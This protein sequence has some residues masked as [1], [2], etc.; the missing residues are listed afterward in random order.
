LHVDG[1]NTLE[2]DVRSGTAVPWHGLMGLAL[3]LAGPAPGVAA[4]SVPLQ[5]VDGQPIVELQ[6]GDVKADFVLES[7]G[8]IGLTVPSALIGAKTAIVLRPDHHYAQDAKGATYTVQEITAN[9]V[10]TG[11]TQLGPVA[12][13]V[14]YG[15]GLQAGQD[16]GAPP[17][18]LEKGIV[19]LAALFPRGILLDFA[20]QKITLFEEGETAVPDR[21]AW[22]ALPFTYDSAGIGV[23]LAVNGVPAVFVLDTAAQVSLV[24]RDSAVFSRLRS[25]CTHPAPEETFCG[26]TTLAPVRTP[27]ADDF[28]PIAV[29]VAQMGAVPY[30]GVLGV[31]FLR[32]RRVYIDFQ[33]RLLLLRSAASARAGG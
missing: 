6:I 8:Q 10:R 3:A 33:N 18:V 19:G 14:R 4:E 20:E 7:A 27:N 23:H 17:E 1:R 26:F 11:E 9:S 12:G 24:G 29:A 28:G 30:D 13:T 2:P 5:F 25:P 21:D 15:F 16:D 31:D 32:T 22:L